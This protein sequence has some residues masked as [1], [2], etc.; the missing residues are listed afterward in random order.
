MQGRG[1]VEDPQPITHKICPNLMIHPVFGTDVLKRTPDGVEFK[2]ISFHSFCP[3]TSY[4]DSEDIVSFT[5]KHWRQPQ[6]S[7]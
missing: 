7:V 6:A 1:Q 2:G 5:L 3:L 4:D